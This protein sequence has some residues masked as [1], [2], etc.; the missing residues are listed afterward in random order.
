MTVALELLRR[1]TFRACQVA[2]VTWLLFG[3]FLCHG[4]D[5]LVITEIHYHPR[6]AGDLAQRQEYI[7]IYNEAPGPIDLSGYFFS[8]GIGFTFPPGTLLAGRQYLVIA[9]DVDLLRAQ[10]GL[11]NVLGN[12]S[13]ATALD[14]GGERI[15]IANRS[16]A[17]VT[18]VD[19]NDRNRWPAGAEA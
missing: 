2:L 5:A 13:S 8:E 18:T 12:W 16:G 6:G 4:V 19:Y 7:E 17:I 3:V 15:T 11:H 14:N 10:H 1:L 9:A